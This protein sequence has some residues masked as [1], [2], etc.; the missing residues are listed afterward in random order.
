MS[1]PVHTFF[2][3]WEIY[4]LCIEHNTLHHR[5]VGEILRRELLGTKPTLHLP[6]SRLR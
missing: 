4:R 3:Q 2:S 1:D 6:R 5:E